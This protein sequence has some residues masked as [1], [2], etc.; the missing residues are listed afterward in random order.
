MDMLMMRD[1]APLANT[2]SCIAPEG[3]EL[4]LGPV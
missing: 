3:L 2:G 1:T 4:A